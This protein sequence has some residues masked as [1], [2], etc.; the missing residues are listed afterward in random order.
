MLQRPPNSQSILKPSKKRNPEDN[1]RVRV[2][3]SILFKAVSDLLA[4]Y[5]VSPE[6][7]YFNVEI[8]KVT[9]LTPSFVLIGQH[10]TYEFVKENVNIRKRNSVIMYMRSS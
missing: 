7:P 5:E 3:N 8:S 10:L 2:L 9:T 1:S 4:S 6:L